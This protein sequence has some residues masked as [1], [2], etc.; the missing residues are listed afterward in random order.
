MNQN[1][2]IIKVFELACGVNA[3]PSYLN[4][5]EHDSEYREPYTYEDVIEQLEEDN[6]LMGFIENYHPEILNEMRTEMMILE[7]I[8]N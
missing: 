3:R 4:L 5:P 8:K 7:D 6:K 2:F 1:E